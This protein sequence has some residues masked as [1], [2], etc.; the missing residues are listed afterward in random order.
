LEE[1]RFKVNLGEEGLVDSG[2]AQCAAEEVD[3]MKLKTDIYKAVIGRRSKDTKAIPAHVT[4]N[5]VD[6]CVRL[7]VRRLLLHGRRSGLQKRQN[8]QLAYT[9]S[10]SEFEV[11]HYLHR[12]FE[13]ADL[14][15]PVSTGEEFSNGA[16][17]A[18]FDGFALFIEAH[19]FLLEGC[20]EQRLLREIWSL[21][22]SALMKQ[23]QLHELY[24]SVDQTGIR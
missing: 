9:Y 21:R 19:S 4:F 12:Y 18:T 23:P 7:R 10:V 13:N 3:C 22:R 1:L 14:V 8:T 2:F 17:E 11:H 20:E 24:P 15:R 6:F 16:Y 5:Y